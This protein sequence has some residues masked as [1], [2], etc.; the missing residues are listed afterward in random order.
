MGDV[1]PPD[2]AY[3]RDNIGPHR[4]AGVTGTTKCFSY[5]NCRS[6][7]RPAL[8]V[9]R[10]PARVCANSNCLLSAAFPAATTLWRRALRGV[11]PRPGLPGLSYLVPSA[12][13]AVPVP[14]WPGAPAA[15][16]PVA[17][18]VP[19]VDSFDASAGAEARPGPLWLS[20]RL[21]RDSLSET[22]ESEWW[23]LAA[24]GGNGGRLPVARPVVAGVVV[25]VR[26]R[27]R[28]RRPAPVTSASVSFVSI[29]VAASA[30]ASCRPAPPRPVRGPAGRRCRAP[31]A[32]AGPG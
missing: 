9:T 23:T 18:L 28:R 10:P 16:A 8:T 17:G 25:G 31:C 3:G 5:S 24:A 26:C 1:L 14:W 22:A 32:C 20:G 12:S 7:P 6:G 15:G 27:R 21:S 30:S 29:G 13:G 19:P 2:R 11:T 4:C